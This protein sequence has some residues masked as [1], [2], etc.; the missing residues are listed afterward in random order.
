MKIHRKPL[1]LIQKKNIT[2]EKKDVTDLNKN[3][4][5]RDKDKGFI[6]GK[7]MSYF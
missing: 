3:V 1:G 7:L 4:T 5:D 2:D 6:N